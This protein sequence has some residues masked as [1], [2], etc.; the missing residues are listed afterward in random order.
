VG[1]IVGR[2][3]CRT[4]S[5]HHDHML[6]SLSP[7]FRLLRADSEIDDDRRVSLTP[8]SPYSDAT[9]QPRWLATHVLVPSSGN[10]ALEALTLVLVAT[11]ANVERCMNDSGGRKRAPPQC[12]KTSL[13]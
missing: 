8:L 10:R 7:T 3:S 9:I 4:C 6:K 2:K 12:V 11:Y 1:D 13:A 5:T